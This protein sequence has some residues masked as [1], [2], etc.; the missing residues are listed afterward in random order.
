MIT[1]GMKRSKAN[2]MGEVIVSAFNPNPPDLTSLLFGEGLVTVYNEGG[3]LIGRLL[4][5]VRFS[6]IRFGLVWFV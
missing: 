5:L 1:G 3:E 4:D 2:S 6:S